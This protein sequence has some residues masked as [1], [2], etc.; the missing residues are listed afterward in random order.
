MSIDTTS[1][2][3]PK[4]GRACG[5]RRGQQRDNC[6]SCE[7]TGMVID[8]AAIRAAVRESLTNGGA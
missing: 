3:A 6:P 4:T 5:C 2:K 1:R 8:F 7:G